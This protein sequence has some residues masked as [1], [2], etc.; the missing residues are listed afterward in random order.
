M[1][2]P[3]VVYR[4]RQLKAF[5]HCNFEWNEIDGLTVGGISR[6]SPELLREW[7]RQPPLDAH[8][9]QHETNKNHVDAAIWWNSQ[10]KLYGLNLKVN[11][12]FT[13]IRAR[14]LIEANIRHTSGRPTIKIGSLFKGHVR[15]LRAREQARASSNNPSQVTKNGVRAD[16]QVTT[17]PRGLKRK[18]N[19]AFPCPDGNEEPNGFQAASPTCL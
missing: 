6:A 1:P 9:R 19:E 12:H 14:Q 2:G 3:N 17:I 5:G 8:L 16:A 15:M 4:N 7:C 13:V 10:A 18:A 11:T